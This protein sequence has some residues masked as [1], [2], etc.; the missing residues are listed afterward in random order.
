M[1]SP[2]H[3]HDC[4]S[5]QFLGIVDGNNP[6]YLGN[7]EQFDLYFCP[8]TEGGGSVVARYGVSAEYTSCPIDSIHQE[9]HPALIWAKHLLKMH[10]RNA[11]RPKCLKIIERNRKDLARFWISWKQALDPDS[12]EE[13]DQ[14]PTSI[15]RV[16]NYWFITETNTH[17]LFCAVVDAVDQEDAKKVVE[18]N[19]NPDEKP[20]L[21]RQW[22]FCEKKEA[23]WMPDPDRFR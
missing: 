10:E 18:E 3:K 13:F 15:G 8:V 12:Q 17:A 4:T 22:R 1:S 2:R 7:L 20:I 23:N 19:F 16:V 6:F 21:D 9:S 14:N 5:C 11:T